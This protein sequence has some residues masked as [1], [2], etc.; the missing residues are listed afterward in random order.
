MVITSKKWPT[1]DRA[2]ALDVVRR[3][4][5]VAAFDDLAATG[6]ERIVTDD[7]VNHVAISPRLQ[8]IERDRKGK[9]IHLIALRIG[10]GGQ[11]ESISQ[12]EPLIKAA[13]RRHVSVPVA[14]CR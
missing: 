8:H 5:R 13:G 2:Q 9:V 10:D 7:T 4:L 14:R 11:P 1:G 3:R 6:A 12:P